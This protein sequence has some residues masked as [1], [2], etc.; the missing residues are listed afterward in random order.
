MAWKWRDGD[1]DEA[2]LARL[3]EDAE[4]THSDALVLLQR[5]ALVGEWY[6]GR[7]RG[8]ILTMS[9]TKSIVSLVIGTLL[10]DGTLA[11]LDQPI[12]DYYPEWRQGRKR[13]VTLRQLLNHTSGIQNHPNAGLEVESAPDWVQL[14]LCAEL[15]DPPGTRWAYNN[16]AVNLLAGLVQKASGKRLDACLEGRLLH[17]FGI[18]THR[19]AYDTVG[20]P[21]AAGGLSLL[22]TDFARL[23]QLVLDHGVW[24]RQQLVS[25]G[26]IETMLAQG[27]PFEPRGGLLWF[28]LPAHERYAVGMEVVSRMRLAQVPD[29][30]VT[31]LEPLVG[32]T[33]ASRPAYH[34]ALTSAL[35]PDWTETMRRELGARG[36]ELATPTLGE[37]VG[38]QTNGYLGQYLVILPQAGIVAV[39]M[40]RRTPEYDPT[41]DG[42]PSFIDRV[43]ALA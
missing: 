24:Q 29:A 40:V 4:A 18:R 41:T 28:R 13:D 3:V 7:E 25:A 10:D 17:P 37:I 33:F 8:P 32:T 16:K 6:F 38:Y 2:L 39:R 43:Q 42:F 35:G 19:W 30:F 12:C 14:A 23:G 5:G 27:Q 34:R 26:W 21:Y 1:V 15:S 31:A 9:C 20:N 11:G 22:P 36:I